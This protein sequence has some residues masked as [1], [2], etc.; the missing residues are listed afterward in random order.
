MKGFSKTHFSY[1]AYLVYAKHSFTCVIVFFL[2]TTL[3]GRCNDFQLT[4]LKKKKQLK[5]V[6]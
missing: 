4:D 6:K 3:W 1:T 2:T 5:F